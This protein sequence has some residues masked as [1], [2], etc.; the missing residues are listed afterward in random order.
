MKIA[1]EAAEGALVG[2]PW[3]A[4]RDDPRCRLRGRHRKRYNA[5]PNQ[6]AAQS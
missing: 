4:G 5:V 6:F 3:F 2:S 1:G